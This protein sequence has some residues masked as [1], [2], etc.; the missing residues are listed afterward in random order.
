MVSVYIFN[1]H[2]IGLVA[3][4]F[5]PSDDSMRKGE[6]TSL[7]ENRQRHSNCSESILAAF[8][9]RLARCPLRALKYVDPP[10]IVVIAASAVSD[11]NVRFAEMCQHADVKTTNSMK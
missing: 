7:C 11:L 8:S 1:K 2:S 6:R 5:G 3:R 9:E 10:A 4:E